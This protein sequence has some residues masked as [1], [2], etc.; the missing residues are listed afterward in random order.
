[1]TK[2]DRSKNSQYRNRM[3]RSMW[4]ENWDG[5]DDGYEYSGAPAKRF[6]RNEIEGMFGGVCAGIADYFDMDP[7]LVRAL[8]VGSFFLS[9]GGT[10]I[11][12]FVIWMI[13]PSDNRAPYKKG[14]LQRSSPRKSRKAAKADRKAARRGMPVSDMPAQSFGQVKNK[15]RSLEL[16][17]QDLERSITSSEWQ[18]RREFKDLEG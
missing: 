8:T 10:I 18:L 6:Y 16:R 5:S 13:S 15:Y 7:V 14:M 1:M 17:L 2:S 4:D 3:H 12:Y 9:G 11:A